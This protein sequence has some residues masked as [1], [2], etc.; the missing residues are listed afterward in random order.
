MTNEWMKQQEQKV[1]KMGLFELKDYRSAV[2]NSIAENPIK[3]FSV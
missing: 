1:S 2:I 3:F